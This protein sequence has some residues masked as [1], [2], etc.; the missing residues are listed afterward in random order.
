M[1]AEFI[2]L[3]Q[4]RLEHDW[5]IATKLAVGL[6]SQIDQVNIVTKHINETLVW[7]GFRHWS[8]LEFHLFND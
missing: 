4:S 6:L 5:I 2:C 3:F 1:V 7:S 8:L